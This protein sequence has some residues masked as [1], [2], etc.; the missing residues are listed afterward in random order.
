VD[1]ATILGAVIAFGLVLGSVAM[2]GGMAF[3]NAPSVMIVIGG[4][5]GAV[6]LATSMEKFQ[7]LGKVFSKALKVEAIPAAATATSIVEFAQIARREGM[8]SLEA[9]LTNADPFM[10]NG[11]QLAIDGI[12]PE[13]VEDIMFIDLD[14]M[15]GRHRAGNELMGLGATF[16]PAM[17]LIGTLIGL[18]QMLQNMSDPST[19]GPAMAVALLT[20]FYGALLANLIFLPVSNK[21]KMRSAAEV[22]YCELMMEGVMAIAKGESPRMVE[23]K[24]NA[25]LPPADRLSLFD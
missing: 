9:A 13:V 22:E 12:A 14:R 1:I 17:G 15:K 19:I 7:S 25:M 3:V 20:T 2:G 6:M 5:T 18:V 11:I 21:L 4:T 23:K 10:A 16:A 24:L 8:L